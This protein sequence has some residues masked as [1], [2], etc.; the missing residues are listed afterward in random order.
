MCC[1]PDTVEGGVYYNK[2]KDYNLTNR[3]GDVHG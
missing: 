3:Y 1:V 2:L